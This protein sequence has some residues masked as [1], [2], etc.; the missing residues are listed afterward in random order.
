MNTAIEAHEEPLPKQ[1]ENG[2]RPAFRLSL[3]FIDS[4]IFLGDVAELVHLTVRHWNG[5]EKFGPLCFWVAWL[6]IL[7]Y[8]AG[9]GLVRD[10]RDI[11]QDDSIETKPWF[12]IENAMEGLAIRATSG[13]MWLALAIGML[14][15]YVDHL[16]TK[17][18]Q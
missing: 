16:L 8:L 12:S 9:I 7:G 14:L 15:L 11:T 3:F 13:L 5:S 6:L 4:A 17:L 10:A 1:I 2:R 18:G